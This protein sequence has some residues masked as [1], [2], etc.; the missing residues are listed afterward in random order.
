V[1]DVVFETTRRTARNGV[2]S[3]VKRFLSAV[4]NGRACVCVDNNYCNKNQKLPVVFGNATDFEVI[5]VQHV[6]LSCRQ[7]TK[8][9]YPG[10]FVIRRIYHIDRKAFVCVFRPTG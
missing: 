5:L 7:V 8:P 6:R 10:E 2:A 4:W 9:R 3:E 1:D